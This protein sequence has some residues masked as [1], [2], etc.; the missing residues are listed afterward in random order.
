MWTK[1][2][3][4]TRACRDICELEFFRDPEKYK[5]EGFT[6]KPMKELSPGDIVS[7]IAH[8]VRMRTIN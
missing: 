4:K 5:F 3:K 1:G 7:G 6:H 2:N 8:K